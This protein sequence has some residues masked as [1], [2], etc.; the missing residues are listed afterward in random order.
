MF[1]AALAGR[2]A[3]RGA[4]IPAPARRQGAFVRNRAALQGGG[5]QRGSEDCGKCQELG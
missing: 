1:G 4:A 3:G 5:G 2:V